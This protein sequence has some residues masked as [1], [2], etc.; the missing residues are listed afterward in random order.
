[1]PQDWLD[2]THGD[3]L[4]HLEMII[5]CIILIIFATIGVYV[6]GYL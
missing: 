5:I 4:M 3:D 2:F 6:R 1:M